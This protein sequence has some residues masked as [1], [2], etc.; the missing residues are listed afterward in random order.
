[1]RR[2][3]GLTRLAD[4]ALDG[5]PHYRLTGKIGAEDIAPMTA[6]M[7]TGSDVS[8]TLWIGAG[9]SLLR[10]VHITEKETVAA[11]PT[12]W[13]IVLSAFDIPVSI[14]PPPVQ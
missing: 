14:Q 1:M 6:Y 13:D 11:D 5:K 9:D 8:F 12:E 2:A 3:T 7:V 10:R 4:E